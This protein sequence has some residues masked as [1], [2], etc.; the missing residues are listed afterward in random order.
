[1]DD[2]SLSEL[3]GHATSAQQMVSLADTYK[4]AGNKGVDFLA[5]LDGS[6]VIGLCS[7][8]QINQRLSARF[9][10]ELYA[11]KPV[12][13]YLV[14]KPFIISLGIKLQEVLQRVHERPHETFYD[15]IILTNSRNEL[16]G[17]ISM[18]TLLRLEHTI[19]QGQLSQTEEHR[20]RLARKNLQLERMTHELESTNRKLAEARDLAEAATRLK[21]EF[22]ANMSHEIRTP[23]NGVVGMLSLLSE[24]QLDEEQTQLAA[25]ADGSANALLRIIND[26]LDFSKIEAGKLDIHEEPF[27]PEELLEACTLLFSEPARAKN[28]KLSVKHENLPANLLGDEVRLRQIITNLVSNAVKFT[29]DGSV[30]VRG[31]MMDES[32]KVAELRIDIQD[33]GIGISETDLMKLFQPFVQAD[34]STSRN[35]GG[36]GLGLAISR[37]LA[38]LMGGNVSCDS[39]LHKG[40]TFSISI[41]LK[42]RYP[43]AADHLNDTHDEADCSECCCPMHHQVLVAEDNAV[44]REVVRRFLKRLDCNAVFVQNGLEAM[45]QLRSQAFDLILMDCQMPGMDGYE[46]TRRIREGECGPAKQ[47]VFISAMTA[48][49]MSGDRERCFEAGMDAY[50]AKPM[51]IDD[52]KQVISICRTQSKKIKHPRK[53]RAV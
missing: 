24:T 23:L 5:V 22:L 28:I 36:T 18:E 11:D 37:K 8:Q 52:V 48:H 44:N 39:E 16:I 13:A 10:R 1:M 2:F 19:L 21:S 40:S 25:A 34:G 9:G 32:E 4:L 7:A 47:D 46:T 33:T 38:T 20:E 17:L 51:R 50:I 43:E 27:N 3:V 12:G 30:T 29:Q 53:E 42:K 35:F 31:Y 45:E 6:Q 26:I 14:R 15:D 49:V 41:P